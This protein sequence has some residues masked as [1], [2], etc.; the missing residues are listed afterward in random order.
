MNTLAYFENWNEE[1][2]WWKG[3]A[4]YFSPYE[5]AAMCSADYDGHRCAMGATVGVKNADP[6]ALMV[7]AAA[8]AAAASFPWT[9]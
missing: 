6:K 1:N 3:R 8:A 2:K 5:F 4:A 7:M 9:I